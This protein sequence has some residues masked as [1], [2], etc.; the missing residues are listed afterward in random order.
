MRPRSSVG[1]PTTSTSITWAAARIEECTSSVAASCS[2]PGGRPRA[3]TNACRAATSAERLPTVP[4]CTKQPP[5]P[6]GMSARSATQR[7]ASF[8]A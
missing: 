6:S 3:V 2:R 7:S 4:P 8:S 5:L 1:T